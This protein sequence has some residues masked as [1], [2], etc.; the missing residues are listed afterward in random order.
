MMEF[1]LFNTI[2]SVC[3]EELQVGPLMYML[4]VQVYSH[5]FIDNG[6]QLNLDYYFHLTTQLLIVHV[7]RAWAPLSWG[8]PPSFKQ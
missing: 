6:H 5:V 4:G 8:S 3:E 7:Y 2:F 1:F